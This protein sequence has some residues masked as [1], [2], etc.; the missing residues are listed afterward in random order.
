MKPSNSKQSKQA[1]A[2]SKTKTALQKKCQETHFRS[3]DDIYT[4]YFGILMRHAQ[5]MTNGDQCLAEDLVS[6]MF[7]KVLNR[8]PDIIS[9]TKKEVLSYLKECVFNAFASHY[10]KK[11]RRAKLSVKIQFQDYIPANE[12]DP[13][14]VLAKLPDLQRECLVKHEEGFTYEEIAT[15]LAINHNKVRNSI[16]HGRKNLKDRLCLI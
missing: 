2:G 4:T 1:T 3:I 6:S 14:E 16:Y 13:N 10:Q 8:K 9:L 5:R 12:Y 7:V 15:M 11:V